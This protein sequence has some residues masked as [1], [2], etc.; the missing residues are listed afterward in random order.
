[1]IYFVLLQTFFHNGKI[2]VCWW[3]KNYEKSIMKICINLQENTHAE[4]WFQ[5]I[6]IGTLLKLYFGIGVPL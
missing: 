3:Y 4:V 6:C 1:M 2:P 5:K